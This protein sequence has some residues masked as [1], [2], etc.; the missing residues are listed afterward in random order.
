MFYPYLY[1]Y[2]FPNK[3]YLSIKNKNNLDQHTI[4]LYI[5]FIKIILSYNDTK[6][7]LN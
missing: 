7:V 4:L 2:I 3:I 1:L 5:S 6:K